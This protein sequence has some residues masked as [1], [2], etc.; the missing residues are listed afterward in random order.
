MRKSNGKKFNFKRALSLFLS[1]SML[2][3]MTVTVFADNEEPTFSK[4]TN[5]DSIVVS[6]EGG[7]FKDITSETHPWAVEA[8]D[9]MTEKGIINGTSET[10]FSPDNDVTKVQALLLI[11]RMLGYN[12]DAIQSYINTIYDLYANELNNLSTAYKKEMSYL[13]FNGAFTLEEIKGMDFDQSLTREEVALF[14]S[15]ADKADLENYRI[16]SGDLYSDNDKISSG[17]DKSVY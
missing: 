4:V 15:K 6:E 8:V 2:L 3:G 17:Y 9:A 16:K 5:S 12:D 13:V 10:T 1:L 14:L 7:K 11:S